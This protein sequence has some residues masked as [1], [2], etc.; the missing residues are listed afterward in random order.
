MLNEDRIR[1][2]HV[3]S[4]AR[5]PELQAY[6]RAQEN[7]ESY[8]EAAFEQCLRHCVAEVVRQQKEVG[9]DFVSDG[10]FG[11]TQTWA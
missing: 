9:I 4:L 7:G 2:T 3:G 5:P 1:V 10:E 8:D 6:L 11:K